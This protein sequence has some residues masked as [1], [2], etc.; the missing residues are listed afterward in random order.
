[1]DQCDGVF[2]S[3]TEPYEREAIAHVTEWFGET[4]REVYVFGPLFPTGAT[5]N[6]G[7]QKQSEKG[8][9]IIEFL[10]KA[11]ETDGPNSVLYVRHTSFLFYAR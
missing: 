9:E 7:E 6:A 8:V 3:T 2:L 5:A 4:G 10:Q 11:L 1:M